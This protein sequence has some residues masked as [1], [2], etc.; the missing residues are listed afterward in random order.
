M[1]GLECSSGDQRPCYEGDFATRGVG[2]CRLGEQT[3]QVNGT[4]GACKNQ[5]TPG[6]ETCD[7]TLDNDCDGQVNEG[8]ASPA[9]CKALSLN[10]LLQL[11][12]T[13]LSIEPKQAEVL[14]ALVEQ[15]ALLVCSTLSLYLAGPLGR[16]VDDLGT[17]NIS[18]YC[19]C[20]PGHQSV[21]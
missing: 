4:W 9:F 18:G 11:Q 8:C 12:A 13:Y 3:C 2:A 20:S 14:L 21:G 1:L 15:G 10:Q 16:S 5:G 7:D 6:P 19:D 17:T